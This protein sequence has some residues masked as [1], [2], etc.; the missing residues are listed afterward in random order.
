MSKPLRYNGDVVFSCHDDE[1]V[2]DVVD[3]NENVRS[4][5]FGTVARQ[6]TM[7]RDNPN[8]LALSYTHC[9]MTSLVFAP[10]PPRSALALGLGGGSFVK[11]LLAQC[12]DCHVDAVERRPAVIDVA[13]QY[14]DLPSSAHPKLDIHCADA[15]QFLSAKVESE[16]ASR[17]DLILVDL[18]DSS[19]MAAAVRSPAF[20]EMCHQLLTATGVL[21]VNMWY[22]YREQEEREARQSLE[23]TFTPRVLY[24]PVAGKLNCVGFAFAEP[25]SDSDAVIGYRA[26]EW[27]RRTGIDFPA[28]LIELTRF[29][30]GLRV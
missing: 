6:S 1:G 3:E 13:Q 28:R 17:Y 14:F 10:T 21:A 15:T 20:F 11:F 26:I 29:N 2:I 23:G 19:G 7:F 27:K 8:A 5:Q 18:H 24:L 12:R 25:P 30:N 9:V 4:M 16:P 22:G